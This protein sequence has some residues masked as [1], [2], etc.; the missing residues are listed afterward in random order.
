[1]PWCG[2][3]RP[4]NRLAWA[5]SVRGATD[6]AREKTTPSRASRSIAGVSMLA[7]PYGGSRSARVV[8]RVTMSRLRGR[9]GVGPAH[10]V[11]AAN[12]ID[13]QIASQIEG[14]IRR[15]TQRRRV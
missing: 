2:G 4:V 10:A 15:L 7:K 3:Y 1:M 13:V 5:G 6:I 11:A 12:T 9:G 14:R 8:S